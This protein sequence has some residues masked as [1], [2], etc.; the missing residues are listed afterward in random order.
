MAGHEHCSCVMPPALR[1]AIRRGWSGLAVIGDAPGRRVRL[2]C[3]V[4]S[5]RVEALAAAGLAIGL[6]ASSPAGGIGGPRR[7]MLALVG[8]P[9]LAI[10]L[11]LGFADARSLLGHIGADREV[12]LLWVEDVT[13]RPLRMD[14]VGLS[15]GTSE[16]L[17]VEAAL[18]GEWRTHDPAPS[19]F[20]AREWAR[21][22]RAGG[23]PRLARGGRRGAAVVVVAPAGGPADPRPGRPDIELAFPAGPPVP[24]AGDA[25]RL[26]LDDPAQRSLARDL[27]GQRSVAILLIDDRGRWL[28]QIE[29]ELGHGSRGLIADAVRS[30]ARRAG[31]SRLPGLPARRRDG[32]R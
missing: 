28:A 19:G 27:R 20:S 7:V 14:V 17:R 26:W 8:D 23:P 24:E 11:D 15:A 21:E 5:G 18:Q 32:G 2:A 6:P 25:I 31:G 12:D 16:R 3:V 10:T 1:A 29:L 22:A 30:S 13:G 4:P 9:S